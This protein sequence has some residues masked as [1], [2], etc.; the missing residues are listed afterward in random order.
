M[1]WYFFGLSVLH[2][3]IIIQAMRMWARE[4]SVSALA[5]GIIGVDML[6]G[7]G[8]TAVGSWFG[9]GE[10]LLEL[11]RPRGRNLVG[12]GHDSVIRSRDNSLVSAL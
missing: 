6:Y 10:I 12:P 2:G 3:A 4:S 1:T 7:I 9:Q 5:I 8:L 11:S